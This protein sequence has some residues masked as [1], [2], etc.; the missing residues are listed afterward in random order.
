MTWF[1]TKIYHFFVFVYWR[2]KRKHSNWS[3]IFFGPMKRFSCPPSINKKQSFCNKSCHLFL[4]QT[5]RTRLMQQFD[6]FSSIEVA[7]DLAW[8]I[9]IFFPNKWMDVSR[10]SICRIVHRKLG[11]F[12]A[13]WIYSP[14][15]ALRSILLVMSFLQYVNTLLFIYRWPLTTF[16]FW[17]VS[18]H[19]TSSC[20]FN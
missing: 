17:N 14:D 19:V 1:V 7:S 16:F 20:Q 10:W 3:K 11:L 12:M 18:C 4:W 5:N 9:Y 2:E 15:S 13:V 8:W 6:K